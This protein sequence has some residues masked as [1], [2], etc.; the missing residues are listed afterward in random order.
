[1]HNALGVVTQPGPGAQAVGL[2]VDTRTN[3]LYVAARSL[4]CRSDPILLL[5]IWPGGA[6]KRLPACLLVSTLV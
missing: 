6:E 2:K 5:A 1:M 4:G 3:Y